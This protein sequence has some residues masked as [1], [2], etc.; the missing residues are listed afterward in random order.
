MSKALVIIDDEAEMED[1]YRMMLEEWL[2]QGSLEFRFFS[3]PRD[4]MQWLSSHGKA[5]LLLTDINMPHLSG[6]EL[7]QQ[8]RQAGHRIPTI[9]IS[10]YEKTDYGPELQEL[11]V[12]GFLTKPLD[13]S[14]IMGVISNEL[15]LPL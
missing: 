10:G 15:Q 13:Y 3:D 4:F 6:V 14:Q 2:R 11:E 12:R 5:D 7:V 1:L 9:F 8:M